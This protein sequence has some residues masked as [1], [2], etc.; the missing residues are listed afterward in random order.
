MGRRLRPE[1]SFQSTVVALA[2]LRGWRVYHTYD[3]RRSN[4]GWPD[5]FLCHPASGRVVVRELKVPPNTVTP[6]QRAWL[7]ALRACGVDA[8]VWTPDDWK[9]IERTLEDR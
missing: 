4:H 2:R 8:S 3:S 1:E 6:E 9:F 5:L 7:E